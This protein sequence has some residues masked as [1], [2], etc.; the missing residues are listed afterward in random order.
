MPPTTLV[1]PQAPIVPKKG[2]AKGKGAHPAEATA[3]APPTGKNANPAQATE[4]A[5]S[6]AEKKGSHGAKGAEVKGSAGKGVTKGNALKG[7]AKG[8][9]PLH[10][11][12]LAPPTVT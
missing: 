3:A 11:G 1:A 12:T 5:P 10:I 6:N 9:Q 7:S 4:A 2:E 8:S